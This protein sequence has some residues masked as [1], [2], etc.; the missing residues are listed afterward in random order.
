MQ[1]DAHS[2]AGAFAGATVHLYASLMLFNNLFRDRKTETCA[3][4]LGGEKGLKDVFQGLSIHTTT[5]IG[6]AD[7]GLIGVECTFYHDFTA[8]A[9]CPRR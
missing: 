3:P 9:N 2:Y 8:I 7:D 6:D 5:V 1:G 4:L